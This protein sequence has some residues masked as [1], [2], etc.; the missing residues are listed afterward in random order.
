M[1]VISAVMGRGAVGVSK[2]VYLAFIV[3][4][5]LECIQ[6]LSLSDSRVNDVTVVCNVAQLFPSHQVLALHA[7]AC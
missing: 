4:S 3:V 2:H 6:H 7:A 1:Q 5:A